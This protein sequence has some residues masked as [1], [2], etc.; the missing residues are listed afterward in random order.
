[1]RTLRPYIDSLASGGR[2]PIDLLISDATLHPTTASFVFPAGYTPL[3]VEPIADY[4]EINPIDLTLP[5]ARVTRANGTVWDAIDGLD[6][7]IRALDALLTGAESQLTRALERTAGVFAGLAEQVDRGE[8]YDTLYI[9]RFEDPAGTDADFTTA[10]L[11][12]GKLT[13]E[14]EQVSSYAVEVA[15]ADVNGI[16]D[17]ILVDG[18]TLSARARSNQLRGPL[19][20]TVRAMFLAPRVTNRLEIAMNAGTVLSVSALKPDGSVVKLTPLA[21]VPED[22]TKRYAFANML[23]SGFL[24][25]VR[26]SAAARAADYHTQ[27]EATVS[28]RD[29]LSSE[30][31]RSLSETMRYAIYTRVWDSV[32]R[33]RRTPAHYWDRSALP[34]RRRR[35]RGTIDYTVSLGV[36]AS[37]LEHAHTA[38]WVSNPVSVEGNISKFSLSVDES[39]PTGCCTTWDVSVAGSEWLPIHPRNESYRSNELLSFTAG[40]KAYLRFP[41]EPHDIALTVLD[42]TDLG[43]VTWIYGA[44][45]EHVIGVTYTGDT[46]KQVVA[47]YH[48]HEADRLHPEEHGVT[49]AAGQVVDAVTGGIPGERLD[50]AGGTVGRLE[51]VPYIVLEP[52]PNIAVYADGVPVTVLDDVDSL[53]NP[54]YAR[55]YACKIAGKTITFNR[56]VGNI[57]VYYKYVK[58]NIR[59]RARL[60]AALASSAEMPMIDTVTYEVAHS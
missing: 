27:T 14:H 38:E 17:A 5:I 37:R 42:G 32:R 4:S 2:Q 51:H 40:G 25:T 29:Y 3:P 46:M 44:D 60:D 30:Q 13:V 7:E 12:D 15:V 47:T 22:H 6:A 34:K 48:P 55:V 54:A 26:G 21:G 16:L 58:M 57:T 49:L 23:L 59:V 52:T 1:M 8:T 31:R 11:R 36:S 35:Y 50:L 9:E 41:A 18:A 53:S 28:P 10:V 33:R 19:E 56:A 45:G 24:I 39:L 20:M 43:G